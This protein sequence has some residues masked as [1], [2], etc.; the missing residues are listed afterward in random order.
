MRNATAYV[1]PPFRLRIVSV[2]MHIA[3]VFVTDED[4]KY[5]NMT[6]RSV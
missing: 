3:K 4:L 5:A 1:P 2:H 6:T